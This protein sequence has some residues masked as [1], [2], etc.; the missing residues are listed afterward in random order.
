LKEIEDDEK[1]THAQGFWDDPKKAEHVLK[2]IKEKKSWTKAYEKLKNSVDDLLVIFDFFN[3]GEGNESDLD[4]QYHTTIK[5]LEDLEFL[6]MLSDEEDKMG[7][8]LNINP[9]AGGTESQDWAQ[10]LMRMYIRWG[11]EHNYKIKELDFQEG[12]VAGIKSV[13]LEF[14]GEFAYGY[15]KGENGVHRLV[16]LSP[17]DKM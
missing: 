2:S 15:L 3:D 12:E 1:E 4:I 16:R 17:V 6:N 11:E 8:I 5:I 9:G 13:S 7:A 10:M 14:E